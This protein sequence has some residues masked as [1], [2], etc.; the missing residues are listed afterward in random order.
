MLKMY[1][2]RE[3]ETENLVIGALKNHR[4][5]ALDP[6]VLFIKIIAPFFH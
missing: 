4:S 6:L 3:K 5:A 1:R 2:E